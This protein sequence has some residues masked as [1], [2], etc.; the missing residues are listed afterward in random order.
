MPPTVPELRNITSECNGFVMAITVNL[1]PPFLPNTI[2]LFFP[3]AR[4][5]YK[6]LPTKGFSTMSRLRLSS[7]V[8]LR[9]ANH[10]KAAAPRRWPSQCQIVGPIAIDSR[11]SPDRYKHRPSTQQGKRRQVR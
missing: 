7:P 4:F 6:E 5:A 9:P 8:P 11:A 2:R 1:Y 10:H 3:L